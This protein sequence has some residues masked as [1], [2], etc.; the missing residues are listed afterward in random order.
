[1]RWGSARGSQ[2]AKKN[3]CGSKELARLSVTR[4]TSFTCRLMT[5]ALDG[6]LMKTQGGG[7]S[8]EKQQ[9]GE[10]KNNNGQLFESVSFE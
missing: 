4:L 3:S 9:V 1:M 10:K 8:R 6:G 7:E 5:T 2:P